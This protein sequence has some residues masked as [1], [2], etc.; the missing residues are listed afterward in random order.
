MPIDFE[1]R[2]KGKITQSLLEILLEDASYRIVPLG[3]EEIIREV[4]NLSQE[5]YF[6]L[7]LSNTLRRIPDFFVALHDFQKSFL[8]D[9]KYRGQWDNQVRDRLNEGLKEQIRQWGPVHLVLFLGEAARPTE[10]PASYLG[11]A[12]LVWRD[13]EI[14]I[15]KTIAGEERL[16][17]FG[18]ATWNSFSRFQNVFDGVG[19]RWEEETLTRAIQTLRSLNT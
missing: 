7:G 12:K 10:T 1:N 15:S 11:V 18:E 19:D 6:G 14:H 3:I 13:D 5:E 4:K 9:V 8:V 2:M 16:T 17:R